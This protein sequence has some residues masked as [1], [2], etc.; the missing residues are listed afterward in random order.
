MLTHDDVDGLDSEGVGASQDGARVVRIRDLVEDEH[1]AI[2]APPHDLL[3]ALKALRCDDRRERL[4][5]GL[6][7]TLQ[8]GRPL[9]L[10][11]V[12]VVGAQRLG[13]L[14]GVDD[15]ADH[16]CATLIALTRDEERITG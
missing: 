4:D 14:L 11:H 16:Q 8:G 1:H 5:D 6:R 12:W 2:G 10:D 9:D 15:D 13:G 3:D 7:R